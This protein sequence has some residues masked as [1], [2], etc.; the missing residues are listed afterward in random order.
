M[1]DLLILGASSDIASACAHQ[2]AA[3]GYQVWL[4]GRN[5]EALKKDAANLTIRYKLKAEAVYF[6][7]A[8]F[9][10]HK[11]FTTSLGF[12]PDVVIVAFG[13][14]GD[15][16]LAEHDWDE[17]TRIINSNYTGAVSIL[18]ELANLMEKEKKGVIVGIS[19]VA[20][21]R[22]K[23]NNYIYGSAKAGFTTYLSGL[24]GRLVAAGVHVVT[25]LPGYVDT[26]M[27]AGMKL[28]S[29]LTA[30]PQ[31]VAHDIYK[32]VA[33]KKNIIYSKGLWRYVMLVF[34]SIPESIYKKLNIG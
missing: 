2:Y 4:A 10:S 25:V 22:G 19:S 1:P 21:I 14:L 11:T 33:S 29:P 17:T 23:K 5:M 13:Y 9:A 28:P 16:Q 27:T 12:V 26:K 6:D 7:A 24:R 18:N 8:D 3:K 31:L 15:Q 30:Q 32:A 34:T 20:G